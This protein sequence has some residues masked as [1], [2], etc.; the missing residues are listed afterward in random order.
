MMVEGENKE[1]LKYLR[2]LPKNE[3]TEVKE[4]LIKNL[5][6]KQTFFLFLVSTLSALQSQQP[7]KPRPSENPRDKKP[8]GTSGRSSG[9]R[10][11][12]VNSTK[13]PPSKT[14]EKPQASTPPTATGVNGNKLNF[15]IIVSVRILFDLIIIIFRKTQ[16]IKKKNDHKLVIM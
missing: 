16:K 15:K 6:G 2:S 3:C 8:H 14:S 10:D 9:R 12:S 1:V 11:Y 13:K 7:A 4:Q 5:E